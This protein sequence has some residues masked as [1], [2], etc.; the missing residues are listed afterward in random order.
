MELCLQCCCPL[1]RQI[2]LLT[3]VSD[4]IY[5]L[6]ILDLLVFAVW[7]VCFSIDLR[8]LLPHLRFNLVRRQSE[9]PT[10]IYLYVLIS[11][12]DVFELQTGFSLSVKN[13]T[14]SCFWSISRSV[15]DK[16]RRSFAGW[17]N[18]G[19]AAHGRLYLAARQGQ[20]SGA[21]NFWWR[22]RDS[23]GII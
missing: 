15:F 10:N 1:Y 14:V 22:A 20:F 2:H 3:F 11:I 19:R 4:C 8:R 21:L 7:N 5:T 13:L 16:Y 9:N 6:I 17:H 18:S 23:E 12:I